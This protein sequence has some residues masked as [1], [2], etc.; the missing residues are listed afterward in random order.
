MIH[1]IGVRVIKN[2]TKNIIIMIII[3]IDTFIINNYIV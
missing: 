2:V 3:S 1:F